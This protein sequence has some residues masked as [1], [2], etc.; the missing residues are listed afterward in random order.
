MLK[1]GGGVR[2]ASAEGM[3]TFLA[4]LTFEFSIRAQISI[5]PVIFHEN[6]LVTV[7]SNSA[8]DLHQKRKCGMGR[9]FQWEVSA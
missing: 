8:F 4:E 6:I 3:L 9:S 2:E 5:R 1:G 7:F